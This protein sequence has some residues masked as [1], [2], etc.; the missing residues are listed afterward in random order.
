MNRNLYEFAGRP[1]LSALLIFALFLIADAASARPLDE[2]EVQTAVETWVRQVTS[3]ARPD[4]VIV[5]MEPYYVNEELVAYIADLSDSGFCICGADESLL[6]V[7]VYSPSGSFDPENELSQ[8]FINH[9]AQWLEKVDQVQKSGDPNMLELSNVLSDRDQYWGMLAD[10]KITT[11]ADKG[12][13]DGPDEV[14]LDVTSRWRQVWPYNYYCPTLPPGSDIHCVTGCVANAM[15]GIIRYWE[16]PPSG[17]GED[18]TVYNYR[19]ATDITGDGIPDWR[20]AFLDENP[21]IPSYWSDNK[22]LKWYSD[23]LRINGYWDNSMYGSAQGI[24]RNFLYAGTCD[25]NFQFSADEGM[26]WRCKD[27]LLDADSVIA[28]AFTKYG[29][30]F[31]GT[32]NGLY[33]SD[34]NAIVWAH[35]LTDTV[36]TALAISDAGTIFAGTESNGICRST[37]NGNNW[38]AVNSGLDV[39]DARKVRALAINSS[40][41]IFAGT[42][43][44]VYLSVD[45]GD[46]WNQ[47]VSGMTPLTVYSL[48]VNSKG[49]VFAGTAA[50]G[51]Y[52][53]TNNGTDW[54]S[55]STGLGNMTV[56]SLA[57]NSLDDVFAGT[58][59]GVYRSTDDGS[60]WDKK[61]SGLP[62]SSVIKALDVNIFD[63]IF[64]G[65]WGDGIFM[66]SDGG[67]SW[68]DISSNLIDRKVCALVSNYS[69]YLAVLEELYNRLIPRCTTYTVSFESG[70]Y[71]YDEMEDSLWDP[72]RPEDYSV[73]RLCYHAGISVHMGYGV[74]GSGAGSSPE[75]YVSHFRYDSDAK[76]DSG[77][78]GNDGSGYDYMM[79]E[80][81]WMR[82]VHYHVGWPDVHAWIIFGY[83]RTHLPDEVQWYMDTGNGPIELCQFNPIYTKH[84]FLRYIAPEGVVG[85]VG[86]SVAGDGSPADPFL[87][88]EGAVGAASPG[89]TLI[90]KAGSDNTFSTSTL[91]I[92]G[93][94]ILKGVNAVIRK[95]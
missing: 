86:S 10:G 37:G 51:I 18:S 64:A 59:D 70:T 55:A 32:E 66:S 5:K 4:A 54:T 30:V 14:V 75:P 36:I 3:H 87:N 93:P 39:A 90:F 62:S 24:R 41:D 67:E 21:D 85:F 73:A 57:V 11:N 53:T 19:F 63:Y 69:N 8:F 83:N 29:L 71:N 48:T 43:N 27:S 12:L 78:I 91:T 7:Y 46:H 47:I 44:G 13:Y 88:I 17:E 79:E 33:R 95:E 82:P 22:L 49:Y 6:P 34:Y 76:N 58:E 77:D 80:I 56:H 72:L 52:R 50:D 23:S 81:Q 20:T 15:A 9:M 68:I 16:W 60:D 25:R 28:L 94:H 61:S 35:V 74:H 42:Y 89:S 1:V 84:H 92:G 45:N 65:T 38:V 2:F 40:G 31:A 26:H